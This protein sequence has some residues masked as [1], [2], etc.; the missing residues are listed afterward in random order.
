MTAGE[1][2]PRSWEPGKLLAR[3]LCAVLA[4][5]GVL[6]LVLVLLVSS[7]PVKRWAERETARIL[8]DE[9]GVAAS[10]RV[11]LRLLPLRLAVLDLAVPAADGGSPAFVAESVTVAPRVFALLGG[12]FDLGEIELH[13]PRTRLVVADGKLVN[14]RYHLRERSPSAAKSE[15]DSSVRLGCS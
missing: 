1:R 5:I 3:A 2:A 14:V 13:R 4:A 9:L 8:R 12:R 6:P 10:Y 7:S 15:R 11:E